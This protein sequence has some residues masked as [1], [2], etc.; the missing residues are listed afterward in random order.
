MRISFAGR[1]MIL[2][3][4]AASGVDY[5]S[6]GRS[7]GRS[8][9][10]FVAQ[11]RE[12]EINRSLRSFRHWRMRITDYRCT[13]AA[14]A[15]KDSRARDRSEDPARRLGEALSGLGS[16]PGFGQVS[17]RKDRSGE[18]GRRRDG[19]SATPLWGSGKALGLF[20]ITLNRF[21]SRSSMN[22]IAGRAFRARPM[23][24]PRPR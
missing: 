22:S 10:K 14:V 19:F 16:R 21:P 7:A 2:T 23:P 3:G 1:K 15:V 13:T 24:E 5:S 18:P 20:I 6:S 9:R 4:A 17:R 12:P 11:K 8:M